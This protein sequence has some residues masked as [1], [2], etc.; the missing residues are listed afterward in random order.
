M[1]KYVCPKCEKTKRLTSDKPGTCGECKA[2]L[3]MVGFQCNLC[4]AL[5]TDKEAKGRRCSSCNKP[6]LVKYVEEVT[7]AFEV[8]FVRTVEEAR[9]YC[10]EKNSTHYNE[11]LKGLFEALPSYPLFFKQ[12]F[13][14]EYKNSREKICNPS[15]RQKVSGVNCV[16]Q[17]FQMAG[18]AVP[19]NIPVGEKMTFEMPY[20]MKLSGWTA[21]SLDKAFEQNL[22]ALVTQPSHLYLVSTKEGKKQNEYGHTILIAT[23]ESNDAWIIDF[24]NLY[25]KNVDLYLERMFVAWS[26]PNLKG[27]GPKPEYLS[28]KLGTQDVPKMTGSTNST[29]KVVSKK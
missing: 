1:S 11:Y 9:T 19:K 29:S 4:Q 8:T 21:L 28:V 23:N 6:S 3:E 12:D 18:T 14:V 2:I 24:Q 15:T 5:Y 27:W 16:A 26:R 10:Q 25:N 17:A 22:R 13:M 7:E 20:I